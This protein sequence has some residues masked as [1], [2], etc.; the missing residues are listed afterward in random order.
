MNE[1]YAFDR[2]FKLFKGITFDYFAKLVP[3][4]TPAMDEPYLVF[5]RPEVLDYTSLVEIDGE[6]RGC[7]YLT[8]PVPM[9]ED[10]LAINGEP[11]VSRRTLLDM[12]RELSNVLSGNASQAFGGHWEISVPKTL[13]AHDV[14]HLNLPDSTFV[15]PLR[16]REQ[17]AL[18]VVGLTPNN[19]STSRSRLLGDAA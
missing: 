11:D 14:E 18:L 4:E 5:G 2:Q 16:W 8:S 17:R 15:M 9:L 7:L 19:D 10:L 3:E 12:C 1:R 6:C 13:D